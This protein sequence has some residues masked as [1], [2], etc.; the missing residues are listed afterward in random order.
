MVWAASGACA[1]PVRCP[2]MCPDS[3]GVEN[4]GNS[5]PVQDKLVNTC[6]VV[7]LHQKLRQRKWPPLPIFTITALLRFVRAEAA[8]HWRAPPGDRPESIP[9]QADEDLRSVSPRRFIR[10]PPLGPKAARC[11]AKRCKHVAAPRE[12]GDGG[13]KRE[14]GERTASGPARRS[15]HAARCLPA[16]LGRPRQCVPRA[17]SFAGNGRGD[18]AFPAQNPGIRP[19]ALA[20]RTSNTAASASGP[21]RLALGRGISRPAASPSRWRFSSR[22]PDP[23][24]P[25]SARC[26]RSACPRGRPGPSR[27]KAHGRR[28]RADPQRGHR[29]ARRRA[30]LRDMEGSDAAGPHA[31]S[32]LFDEHAD[33]YCSL[34]LPARI[35]PAPLVPH[36]PRTGIGDTNAWAAQPSRPRFAALRAS[37]SAAAAAACARIAVGTS[38]ERPVQR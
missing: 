10:A 3:A 28:H 18:A 1:A 23:G 4:G 27:C 11:C 13:P 24:P 33:V 7:T 26:S 32:G 2:A 12:K 9:R 14:P 34:L 5:A 21:R 15:Q 19:R 35:G 30:R 8:G 17:A 37:G 31:R 36:W 20:P 22:R 29:P 16:R 6:I 38:L 25:S